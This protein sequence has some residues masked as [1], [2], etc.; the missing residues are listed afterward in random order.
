[1]IDDTAASNRHRLK[2]HGL[3]K[4]SSWFNQY[5]GE[6]VTGKWGDWKGMKMCHRNK[7][8]DAIKVRFE[9]FCKHLGSNWSL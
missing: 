7:Y 2:S 8:I 5:T 6:P 3:K 4:N 1:M 9:R